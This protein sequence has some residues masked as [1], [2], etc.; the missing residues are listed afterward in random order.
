MGFIDGF[1]LPSKVWGGFGSPGS[2]GGVVCFT[3]GEARRPGD[4]CA[5]EEGCM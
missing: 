1:L 5:A 3:F 4:E 2:D